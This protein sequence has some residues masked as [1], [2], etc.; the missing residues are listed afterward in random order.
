MEN[1]GGMQEGRG[2]LGNR[3]WLA[4]GQY[5]AAATTVSLHPT[6]ATNQPDLDTNFVLPVAHYGIGGDTLPTPQ[7]A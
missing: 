6:A 2:F 7:D 3:T 5:E 4:E 1:P